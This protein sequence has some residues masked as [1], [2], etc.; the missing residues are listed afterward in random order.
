MLA[1]LAQ[2]TLRSQVTWSPLD[3][4]WYRAIGAGGLSDAGIAVLP[5][6]ALGIAVVYRAIN[7]LAHAIASIPLVVYERLDNDGKERARDHAA[8]ELLHDRPNAWQTSFRWRH[9]MMVQKILYGNHY[10]EIFPGRGGVGQLVPLSPVTTRI[11]D[12]LADGRLLYVTR[13]T[14]RAGFGPERRLLQDEVLHVRG[15][16]LDGKSGL[17]LPQLAKNAMGLALAAEKHG[18]MFLKKGARFAGVLTVKGRLDDETRKANEAAWQRSYGGTDATGGTPILSDME[19][20][21]ISADNRN[22]QW[23]ESRT[24]Q[25][26]ELLRFIGVP[27]V[28]CGYADK[29]ATYASA[30][31]FFLSFVTHTVRPETEAIAAEITQSI[32]VGAPKYFADFVLE[33]LPVPLNAAPLAFDLLLPSSGENKQS[34]AGRDYN[35]GILKGS[36]RVYLGDEDLCAR[37]VEKAFAWSYDSRTWS[38]EQKETVSFRNRHTARVILTLIPRSNRRP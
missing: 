25:V 24:F 10:S 11:V 19:Y 32:V 12:Q 36:N 20:K 33:G 28:L 34:A 15:F 18:S 31:Q 16:S 9:L 27:G 14:T 8:F 30:E 4:R 1:L 13:N 2:P 29:T 21:A 38:M 23:I 26:E 17:P 5:E 37:K 7:V 6:R 35:A 3:E 22:S